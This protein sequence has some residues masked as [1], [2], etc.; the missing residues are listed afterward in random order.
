MDTDNSFIE[1][2]S[3]S[4]QPIKIAKYPVSRINQRRLS[5]DEF[6]QNNSP[7]P[8]FS[9]S[10][11]R[12]S[13]YPTNP[14]Y[15]T[16]PKA[17]PNP[18]YVTTPKAATSHPGYF[19]TP[20]AAPISVSFST[21]E[22][23][24]MEGYYSSPSPSQPPEPV[25]SKP[26]K[27][28][29]SKISS[30]KSDSLDVSR[31]LPK[32]VNTN[33]FTPLADTQNG[34]SR[35]TNHLLPK[36]SSTPDL[37]DKK[38]SAMDFDDSKPI[39]VADFS[40]TGRY[41]EEFIEVKE[42]ASGAFGSVKQ[43]RHRLDGVDYAVKISKENLDLVSRHDEKM[44]INEVFAHA[45]LFK[46]KH[47]VRYYNSWV[48][49]GRVYI[50]NEFCRGGSL[51]KKIKEMRESGQKFLESELR[52]MVVQILK[53]LQYIH[54]KQMVHLDIKPENIL[55]AIEDDSDSGISVDYKIG[56]LGHVAHVYKNME[57][58]K[59]EGDCRYM[60]PEFLQDLQVKVE[61]EILYKADIFSLGLTI[62]EAASLKPLPK[63]GR[64]YAKLRQGQ[65][66]YLPFYSE[67]FNKLMSSMVNPNTGERPDTSTLLAEINPRCSLQNEWDDHSES[68]K[69]KEA[70]DTSRDNSLDEVSESFEKSE[71]FQLIQAKQ[72]IGDLE[73]EL[74]LQKQ[75]NELLLKK[76]H[77]LNWSVRPPLCRKLYHKHGSRVP[78]SSENSNMLKK[79]KATK[80]KRSKASR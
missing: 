61:P 69:A 19:T 71:T 13:P 70:P 35:K 26:V 3:P 44:A 12:V 52:K 10:R 16:T 45:A 22:A 42:I 20:K 25:F 29:V 23:A 9:R 79:I 41:R 37:K 18:G 75:E 48:E 38:T 27:K 50:Q 68:H 49:D 14:G 6:N 7:S 40:V 76:T 60:A 72:K 64:T 34:D 2:M 47:F 57:K 66:S 77:L 59:E 55:L 1:K 21:P 11:A 30:D 24:P 46:H 67:R 53:G 54:T 56:D 62:Y 51:A 63:E 43:A 39:R 31:K 5:Y 65:L 36:F 58:D 80:A 73:D 8:V 74:R 28:V 15:S 32:S 17:S 4:P 78:F 33:P